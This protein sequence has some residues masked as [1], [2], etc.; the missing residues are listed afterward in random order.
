MSA[1]PA[2]AWAAA[3]SVTDRTSAMGV[4]AW[5]LR[6]QRTAR[7]ERA[8][9]TELPPKLVMVDGDAGRYGMADWQRDK[10]ETQMD[11]ELRLK[12]LGIESI[13]AVLVVEVANLHEDQDAKIEQLL[14]AI[15]GMAETLAHAGSGSVSITETAERVTD[16]AE[17]LWQSAPRQHR[18]SRQE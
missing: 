17:R 8:S 5:R 9:N 18:Q 14:A 15:R 13:L 16:M 2:T 11:K 12:L 1:V 6:R 3:R 4:E 7:N 10:R